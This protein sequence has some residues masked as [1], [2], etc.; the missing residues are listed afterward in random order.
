[1]SG[2]AGFQ[3]SLDVNGRLCLVLGGDDEA[4]EKVSR[5][6]EAGAKIIVINPTLNTELRKLTAS[7]KVIHRGRRFRSTD[8]QGVFFVLNVTRDDR[9]LT[10]EL[11]ELAKTERFL[12]WSVDQ[13]DFSTCIMPA[14][15]NRGMFRMAIS[16]SGASPALAS[17]LRQQCECIF[18]EQ[19][20]QFVNWLGRLREEWQKSEPNDLRRCDQLKAAVEGFQLIGRIEYPKTW[21][22]EHQGQQGRTEEV[23]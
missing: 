12:L 1:M 19:F 8:T 15:V 13:P 16:T 4:A 5:L 6:L 10:K 20:G 17:L 18:D 9:E 21:I 14:V 11:W 7:G 22:E 23:K 3:V 2:N